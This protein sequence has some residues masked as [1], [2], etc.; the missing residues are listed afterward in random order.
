MLNAELARADLV[1]LPTI[2]IEKRARERV[3]ERDAK[4]ATGA[5]QPSGWDLPVRDGAEASAEG[6]DNSEGRARHARAEQ[7]MS[8]QQPTGLPGFAVT[9]PDA[10]G[11]SPSLSTRAASASMSPSSSLQGWGVQPLTKSMSIHPLGS[12]FAKGLEER[13]RTGV[14]LPSGSG[15]ARA[16]K[17]VIMER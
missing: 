13:P 14:V 8:R 11:S 15:G 5:S 4:R 7:R 2:R 12:R 17:G 6:E 3:D 9:N 16:S 10:G 1:R